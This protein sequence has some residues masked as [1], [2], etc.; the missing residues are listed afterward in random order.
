MTGFYSTCFSVSLFAHVLDSCL[1]Y[2]V[3]ECFSTGDHR[4]SMRW[5]SFAC[6]LAVSISLSG[7]TAHAEETES[8]PL[9]DEQVLQGVEDE[10]GSSATFEGISTPD[11][12]KNISRTSAVN[13]YELPHTTQ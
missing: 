10:A 6:L 1:Q 13:D 4:I 9:E 3:Q 11:R 2:G 12:D 8:L 7:L 5:L